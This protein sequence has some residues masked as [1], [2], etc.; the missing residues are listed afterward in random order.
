MRQSCSPKQEICDCV[1]GNCKGQGSSCVQGSQGQ[2]AVG[3]ACCLVNRSVPVILRVFCRAIQP[4]EDNDV[5]LTK[6][7]R[8]SMATE[9]PGM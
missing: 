9:M 8:V 7:K 3:A 2:V 4:L 5:L 6:Q 1:G